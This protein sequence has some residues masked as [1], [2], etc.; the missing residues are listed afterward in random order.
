MVR[1]LCGWQAGRLESGG[2]QQKPQ[3]LLEG[4]APLSFFTDT[5]AEV[6][7][8]WAPWAFAKGDPGK[9]IAAP[10][11]LATLVVGVQLWVP[12]G[13]AKKTSRVG[14]RGYTD[15]QSNEALLRKAMTTKFPSTLILMEL[16]EELSAK[17]CELQLQWIRRDL[18]QLADDLTNESTLDHATSYFEELGMAKRSLVTRRLRWRLAGLDGVPARD[19]LRGN[20]AGSWGG[21]GIGGWVV[22]YA[23]IG[24]SSFGFG[25]SN[26]HVLLANPKDASRKTGAGASGRGQRVAMLFTGQSRLRPGLGR[27]LY[28]ANTAFRA[29]LDRCATLCSDLNEGLLDILFGDVTSAETCRTSFTATFCIQYALVEAWR[30]WG[31]HPHAVLGHSLGEYAAAVAAGVL[32]LEDGIRV[33]MARGRLLDEMC[34]PGEGSMAAVFAPTHEV[35]SAME[36]IQ[37]ARSQGLTIAAMN[38][39]NQTVVSGRA[40]LV[41]DLCSLFPSRSRRLP[42]L[43]AMHSELLAAV[44]PGL[45]KE[46]QTCAFSSPAEGVMFVSCLSGARETLEVA[47]PAYWLSHDTA[48]P[49]KFDL[50]MRSLAELSCT[51]YLEIGPRPLLL[52][53]GQSCIGQSSAAAWL[54]SL[55]PDRCETE[56]MLSALRS[57]KG[58]SFKPPDLQLQRVP[59]VRP[60][61]HPLLGSA[62]MENGSEVFRSRIALWDDEAATAAPVICLFRQHRV[63][64]QAVLPAASHLLLLS[65]ATLATQYRGNVGSFAQEMFVELNDTVFESAFVLSASSQSFAEVQI[66]PTGAKL[67]SRSRDGHAL[68]AQSRST[69]VVGG[70][71]AR[72]SILQHSLVEWKSKCQS[73]R[74]ALDA[75]RT[76]EKLGLEYGP[77]FRAISSWSTSGDGLH[78]LGRLSL[79]LETWDRSLDLHP[80]ILDGAIQLLL[81]ASSSDS[82]QCFLPFSIDNCVIATSLPSWD[83]WVTVLVRTIS[84]EAVSGDV[85]IS[86]DDGVLIARLCRL[87]CRARRQ[88]EPPESKQQQQQQPPQLEQMY[89]VAFME[90]A[91]PSPDLPEKENPETANVIVWCSE[92]RQDQLLAALSWK[93]DMCQFA[94][95]STRAL[96]L[97]GSG[98]FG[99]IAFLAEDGQ[100]EALYSALQV[101]QTA[102]KSNTSVVLVAQAAQPPELDQNSFDPTH[103]GLWG[104]ARSARL[105]M[106]EQSVICLDLPAD[107]ADLTL[108][109]VSSWR[110][111]ELCLREKTAYAARLQK[112][113]FFPRW[114]LQLSL[115]SRGTFASLVPVPQ[116]SKTGFRVAA[117]GL[118]FRDVLNVLDLYPGDPGDPGLDCSGIAFDDGPDA[119][120]L[121]GTRLFGISF[122]C[123]RTF[124]TVKEPRLLVE[125]PVSWS[126][127][128]AAAL[129][130]VF[131]TVDMALCHL[132]GLKA[133]QRVLIHAGAGGVGLTAVQY[134]LRLGALVYATA[135]KEDKRSLL[136]RM[137]VTCV[138][139]SRDGSKF[140]EE[141]ARA[142][143]NDNS[144]KIDVVLNSL[145]HDNFI[146]RSLAFVG[147]GGTFIEIGKRGIW[148]KDEMEKARPDV[149]YRTLAMDTVCEEDP[150]KFQELMKRLSARM[151]DGS[152]DPI[153]SR[154]FDGLESCCE[155]LQVLRKA[156][157][158]GKI[159][160]KVPSILQ[161][162]E[163]ATY[164]ITGGT[165]ALGLAL[166]RA[167]L[168]EGVDDLVLLSRSGTARS[169]PVWLARSAVRVSFWACDLSA[170]D[171][172][173]VMLQKDGWSTLAGVFHLAGIIQDGLLARL[174][175][176]DLQATFGPKVRGLHLL[177]QVLM[178][179]NRWQHL[180]FV[181]AFSSTAAILG[182][183]GQANYAAAN[184]CLDAMMHKWRLAGQRTLSLQWGAWLNVGMAQP[185]S[186]RHL[187]QRGIPL[188]VGLA[189]MASAMAF[190]GV[191]SAVSF[192]NMDWETFLKPVQARGYFTF[193]DSC[194]DMRSID[195]VA[196]EDAN[197]KMTGIPPP[198][199]NTLDWVLAVLAGLIGEVG[200]EDPLTAA[201]L[202]S[203]SAVEFRRKLSTDSGIPLPQTL[204]FD[205]PTA[206]QVSD[207]LECQGSAAPQAGSVHIQKK[208]SVCSVQGNSCRF[209]GV[210]VSTA[211]TSQAWQIF[212]KEVD[213]VTEVPLRRFDIN[214]CFDANMSGAEFV[215]YAR[216][217]S[218]LE[219]TDLFDH[220]LFG[221]SSNEASAIDPQQ[222]NALEVSYAACHD[223]G[224]L[225]KSLAKATIGV[226]VGQCANDWAKTS[227]ERKAGTFMGPG[228]HASIAANRLSFCLGLE[229]VSVAVDTA[230]SS[231]LVA[232]DLAILRL[233]AGLEAVICSGSQLNLIVEP[234]VA[235]SN[236]RL[237]SASGRCRTFDASAD[238]FAR[239]EG[240]G[241][242]F[243]EEREEDLHG[244][245][246]GGHGT[247]LGSM[248]NQDGR[249]S[250]L[251]APNGPAQQ[252]VINAALGL[253]GL[254]AAEV[255]AVECH[256]TGTALGD[257]IEVG[258]LRGTLGDGRLN[259]LFLMAG[260]T[261]VG[262]LEGAAGALGL[263]KCLAIVAQL[264]VPPN[265]HLSSL[266]PHVE[267]ED[268][269]AKP[270]TTLERLSGMV[271]ANVGL[272]SFG[273]GGTNAHALLQSSRPQVRE[274]PETLPAL[275]FRRM[276]FPW[277][278]PVP[279]LLSLKR[280]EGSTVIF[281]VQVDAE[282]VGLC[283]HM[284]YDQTCMSSALLIAFAMDACRHHAKQAVQLKNVQMVAPLFLPCEYD[285]QTWLRLALVEQQFQVLSKPR[286]S[287][288]AWMVHCSGRYATQAASRPLAASLGGTLSI[289]GSAAARQ[290]QPAARSSESFEALCR[291]AEPV[292]DAA[293][294]EL[295]AKMAEGIPSPL[296]ASM[297]LLSDVH[298]KKGELCA[299]LR[300]P[301]DFAK[302]SVH[303]AFLQAIHCAV[304]GLGFFQEMS[305]SLS[306]D[307]ASVVSC[308]VS[309]VD[310]PQGTEHFVLHVRRRGSMIS[311][312]SLP[313]A[314]TVALDGGPTLLDMQD[315]HFRPLSKKQVVAAASMRQTRLD[316][317][318]IFEMNWVSG[319]SQGRTLADEGGIWLMLC[320]ADPQLARGLQEAFQSFKVH[321]GEGHVS[322]SESSAEEAASCP[323]EDTPADAASESASESS[324]SAPSQRSR[325]V[326]SA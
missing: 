239:G 232:L 184:A 106:P 266:N 34:A 194:R 188:D 117:V 21:G 164:L 17:N 301:L 168:E 144:A 251:T 65:S 278:T 169:M 286:L 53:L 321:A 311:N 179:T 175:R 265:L 192:A 275:S 132:A 209:P 150:A 158:I 290:R 267:L 37:S 129:P 104:L 172:H 258:G 131:T 121:P 120:A 90:M 119:V 318:S 317:P 39:P 250:S 145:S 197:Q 198:Y 234:F 69:R 236:G 112:N 75:Y 101:L 243:I 146:G 107:G 324:A 176:Q 291:N 226:F 122:G 31:V 98:K 314:A 216:H 306:Q 182:S 138:A 180:D 299:R 218:M 183:A 257:P 268:F 14:I 240:F 205:Y 262:H 25:G 24:L 141:L 55:E 211:S 134:A 303:P 51:V 270:S 253:S 70:P 263:Q 273:F 79:N 282:L 203:L 30:S 93:A 83:V 109:P 206:Q 227:R 219:G 96:S 49:V 46:L 195:D 242:L 102:S 58:T 307:L 264:E 294:E 326:V 170:A 82:H 220:R 128:E 9:V 41:E 105:E 166:S 59:W 99:C 111:Q 300:L 73:Q 274:P 57:L 43:H 60:C 110:E 167:L 284:V 173:Q 7:P 32:S 148:T 228:T 5:K 163:G 29:A 308:S 26:A 151:M 222:R 241:S 124:A 207:F 8:K 72:G 86:T 1:V 66:L 159:V 245:G 50:A 125:R 94:R 295:K 113:S 44:L 162:R 160:V 196:Q 246:H 200:P 223:A 279:R 302:F 80:G 81:L 6:T 63:S 171:A 156:D 42:S 255:S 201:G 91:S 280:G 38:G 212:C 276:P 84:T 15:S 186:L 89:C 316:I 309:N 305:E 35:R 52:P 204:A 244:Q 304:L 45:E 225:R 149:D 40:S 208:V 28:A 76:L 199:Q 271:S 297:E 133:G 115:P 77:S 325:Q 213:A 16:A 323:A 237:L 165:G 214:E 191:E 259:T 20:R 154:V 260:K 155:A 92:Q 54:P 252:R 95:D 230:C 116:H 12:D 269:N 136:L 87:T 320:P 68:H 71:G 3:P 217:A 221:I 108:M 296:G 67:S 130:T 22:P 157:H 4:A 185:H 27:E 135:G 64:G 233:R 187:C 143:A 19:L 88:P 322:E 47:K 147:A 33:V 285:C 281:E 235:F 48:R 2:R 247:L 13:N 153:P 224:R 313:A 288:D 319:S 74:S 118:N 78:V 36:K 140:E 310:I 123:L 238:G 215:T 315:I 177:Q 100:L 142:L 18:I 229:G 277:A 11:L 261:N 231:T 293:L 56:S 85:E 61:L 272:S 210:D 126:H 249:S 292:A 161:V 283:S 139:S 193:V 62:Q 202:D 152:W 127:V 312:R 248:A 103:A 178:E 97:L 174:D 287:S 23:F 190:L 137:G 10:E 254:I 189:A 256:G 298:I 114:P 181:L 289:L